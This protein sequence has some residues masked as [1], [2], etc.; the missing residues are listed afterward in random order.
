M[1]DIW[2]AGNVVYMIEVGDMAREEAKL[3]EGALIDA[4]D[5]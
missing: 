5:R 3:A 2:A 4:F 1:R